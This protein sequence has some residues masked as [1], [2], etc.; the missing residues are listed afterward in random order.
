MA[1][2]C[3]VQHNGRSV[4]VGGYVFKAEVIELI[5]KAGTKRKEYSKFCIKIS[6]IRSGLKVTAEL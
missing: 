4:T 6:G 1:P 5:K 2:Y 3:F